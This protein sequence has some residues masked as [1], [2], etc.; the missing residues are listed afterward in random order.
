MQDFPGALPIQGSTPGWGAKIPH[1]VQ[2]GQT[3][4][5]G[6]RWHISFCHLTFLTSAYHEHIST[7]IYMCS[8]VLSCS[9]MS[10]SLQPYGQWPTRLLCPWEF[11]RQEYWSGLP[12][13]PPGD[14]PK[15]RIEPRSPTLQAGSLPSEPP[16]KP[17]Y[18]HPY[19][20]VSRILLL[21]P[22]VINLATHTRC[23]H[24]F[25][26]ILWAKYPHR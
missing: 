16:G 19:V 10:N 26:I 20:T 25:A 9:V 2:W 24:F 7:C 21:P 17:V 3:K 23:F 4:K 8:V 13:P 18:I 14:L 11:S 6:N 15:S 1:A 5:K 12:C 22:S